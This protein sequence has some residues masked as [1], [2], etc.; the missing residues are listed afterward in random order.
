MMKKYQESIRNT[1]NLVKPKFF[2]LVGQIKFGEINE[3][4]I[5]IFIWKLLDWKFKKGKPFSAWIFQSPSPNSTLTNKRA[6]SWLSIKKNVISFYESNRGFLSRKFSI[7]QSTCLTFQAGAC[8]ETE[9]LYQR[10]ILLS[11]QKHAPSR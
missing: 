7:R 10:I 6:H 2:V 3:R 4:A 9:K 5:L 11:R 1:T 8:S